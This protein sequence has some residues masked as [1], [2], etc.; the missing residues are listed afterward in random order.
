MIY[1]KTIFSNVFI[2]F[3]VIFKRKRVLLQWLLGNME[4]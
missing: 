2:K 1:V 3:A 4:S